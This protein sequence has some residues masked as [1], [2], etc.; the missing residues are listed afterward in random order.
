MT[1][2]GLA[3]III[4]KNLSV[5]SSLIMFFLSV[6]LYTFAVN[7]GPLS[8]PTNGKVTLTDTMFGSRAIYTCDPGYAIVGDNTRICEINGRWSGSIFCQG[9]L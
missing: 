8:D 6:S 1:T 5:S 7:C 9:K 4:E 2:V 3:V